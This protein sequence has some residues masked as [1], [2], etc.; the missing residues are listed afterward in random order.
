MSE[1]LEIIVRAKHAP[2]WVALDIEVDDEDYY[3]ISRQ[4]GK[5][6][7]PGDLEWVAQLLRELALMIE[8][9]AKRSFARTYKPLIFEAK[10]N[11]KKGLSFSIEVE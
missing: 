2:S 9:E 11:A 7:E 4:S 5:P 3:T 1:T 6:L 10:D 8:P